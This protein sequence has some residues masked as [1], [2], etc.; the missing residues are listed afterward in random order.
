MLKISLTQLEE[1][2]KNPSTFRVNHEN[3]EPSG[4]NPTIYSA[5]RNAV[6]EFHKTSN[7]SSAMNYLES[8]LEKF[9]DQKKC[10]KA[11]SNLLW[12]VEEY[13]KFNWPLIQ[14]RLNIVIPLST[15]YEDSLRLSGQVSRLDIN[16]N[17][18]Y[19]AWLFRSKGFEGWEN[20][21]Q[22]PIIQN[23]VGVELGKN[24][25]P[26][27]IVGIVSFEEHYIGLHE[28]SEVEIAQAHSNLE[29]IFRQMGY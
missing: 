21:L 25:K 10:Q 12:Y 27:I 5:F 11:V 26:P 18:G 24:E 8:H 15:K 2:R 22:M 7:F 17:G 1:A 19:G 20:E 9:S 3:K 29:S 14:T 6:F 28:Y 23:A 13:Q 16:P 4:R